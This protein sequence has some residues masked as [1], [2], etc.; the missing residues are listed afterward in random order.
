MEGPSDCTFESPVRNTES[1]VT[2][3]FPLK[4]QPGDSLKTSTSLNDQRDTQEPEKSVETV[5]NSEVDSKKQMS[6]GMFS[7]KAAFLASVKAWQVELWSAQLAFISLAV[8]MVVLRMYDNRDLVTWKLLLTPNAVIDILMNISKLSALYI[9]A[10]CIGQIRSFHIRTRRK[11]KDW[12]LYDGASR[13]PWGATIIFWHVRT[14]GLIVTMAAL[15]TMLSIII[16]P[17][18]QQLL[19]FPSHLSPSFTPD[20][21]PYAVVLY[22]DS[23]IFNT[24][25]VDPGRSS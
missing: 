23:L 16:G 4:E 17:A 25:A 12:Q 19:I 7:S 13:G 24:S 8:L 6:T 3:A 15:A 1:A 14:P 5:K 9:L 10:S 21:E 18:S 11:L 22:G 20:G 2:V